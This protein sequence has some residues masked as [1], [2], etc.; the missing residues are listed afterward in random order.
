MPVIENLMKRWG[1]VRLSRY[2]L[3]L[4]PEGR[5]ISMRPAVLDGPSNGLLVGWRDDDLPAIDLSG[6]DV[7]A[8]PQPGPPAKSV[9]VVSRVATPAHAAPPPLASEPEEPEDD[10]EWE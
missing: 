5:I 6:W 9:A 2:G 1:F 7:Q 8:R 10:W 3:V 4:T